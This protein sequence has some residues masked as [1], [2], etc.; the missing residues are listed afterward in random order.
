[1]PEQ[2]IETQS[3]QERVYTIANEL[4]AAG[5]KPS[6][7]M[8]LSMLPDV[9]STSTAHKY[10]KQW[11]DEQ[12]ANQQSLYDKL[13]FSEKFTRHFMEEVT[14]FGVQAEQRF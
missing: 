8:V 13:G 10:F 14:R 5:T 2:V 6:V 9:K 3:I 11:K 1:M 12:E 4:Y 7:R